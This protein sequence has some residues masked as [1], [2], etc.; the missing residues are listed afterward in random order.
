MVKRNIKEEH[1]RIDQLQN[2]LSLDLVVE[3]I[4]KENVVTGENGRFMIYQLRRNILEATKI[5]IIVSFLMESGVRLL[6]DSLR[7]A[8]DRGVPVRILTGSY[9]NITQPSAL[10]LLKSEFGDRIDLRFYNN[11]KKSFHTKAYI[12]HAGQDGEM[13]IGSS[14]ISKGALT[15]SVEW[16]YRI[17][18]SEHPKDFEAFCTTFQRLFDKESIPITEQVLYNYSKNWKKPVLCRQ[19]PIY[20]EDIVEER[21]MCSN[22]S[23]SEKLLP[24][25]NNLE[26]LPRGAQLEALYYLERTRQEGY[27]RGIVVA[28]TGIGKTYL[29]AFDSISSERILFVAHREEIL[30]QAMESFQTVRKTLDCGMF[31]GQKK[32]TEKSVTFAL[33]QTL[34]KEEY[35]NDQYFAKD[36]FQYIIIDEFHHAVAKNYQNILNYFEPEFLLGLT[37][38]P[39][40][41][42][43]G[44]VFALCNDNLVYEL[45]LKEAV[46]KGWLV[47]FRYYGVYDDTVDY[48]KITYRSGK[49]NEKELEE[50]LMFS[51]RAELIL[52]NYKKYRSNHA[53][54]F[55]SSKA[56]AY[57]MAKYFSE[58][59][60]PSVAV[61]SEDKQYKT[62]NDEDNAS[63]L[64]YVDRVTALDMLRNGEIRVI[65]SVDMFNEGIDIK[66]TDLLLFLRPT[67]S[68][69]I[70]L[71]QLGRGLRRCKGKKYVTVLDFIGNYKNANHIPFLLSSETYDA[72][73]SEGRML[74][75]YEFPEECFVDFD[76][77]VIDLFRIQA[78]QRVAMN[79]LID[80][81]YEKIKESLGHRPSRA[82][83]VTS[84]NDEMFAYIYRN[85]K[86][87]PL[88]DYLMY[89][90]DKDELT[91]QEEVLFSDKMYQFIHMIEITAMEKSY[92]MPL[93]LAFYNHGNMKD[94]ITA[95]DVYQSFYHYYH[96]GA[97]K[98]DMLRDKGTRDFETWDK[99]E[100]V[101][102]ALRMP[103][104]YML[105]S[106]G[107][108]FEVRDGDTE[109]LLAIREE[110]IDCL[111]NEAFRW[112][113]GD[114]IEARSLGY[115]RRRNK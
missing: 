62:R 74:E 27:D 28:A 31:Y 18:E 32:D 41:M 47:P 54:G 113:V 35:L 98:V 94:S 95:E 44:D 89:L 90:K 70:F 110:F 106:H 103:I 111:E 3:S 14:N 23:S 73:A 46:N 34:G 24:T 1:I 60:I 61:F 8:V 51:K 100:Y 75:E 115:C 99:D 15:D 83:L 87:N 64:Y 102:L 58:H 56:H 39:E 16:N 97:N 63:K 65:F 9:L 30:K 71:Q 45:R 84:L 79:R 19:I 101:K 22:D 12:F 85:S 48:S 11:T 4:Q 76:F 21:Q 38:T 67:Q 108:I 109:S 36:Y 13:F 52:K 26:I 33:V 55:C 68:S 59:Q 7:A 57:Y 107:D 43:S 105:K 92:K 42:D 88:R 82:E 114:A 10:Y 2:E 50:A 93:L 53:L 104:H 96:K 25:E 6:I 40:R 5:D 86:K 37:A 81:E 77:K 66:N 17:K 69:T 112:H 80:E 20:S 78:E 72:K 49:Y 29:A 91:E